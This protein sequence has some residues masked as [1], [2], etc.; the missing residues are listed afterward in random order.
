MPLI[1]KLD[2]PILYL[3]GTY[4]FQI[5]PKDAEI[6]TT[7]SDKVVVRQYEN[8]N[9]IFS[10]SPGATVGDAFVSALNS[11]IEVSPIVIHD[12]SNFMKTNDSRSR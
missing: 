4:D 6:M 1:Q 12:M 9:H 7:L 11:E 10:S 8:L 5:S 2:V 3:R